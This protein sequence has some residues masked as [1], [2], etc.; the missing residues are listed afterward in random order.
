MTRKTIAVALSLL[1][2]LG[3]FAL[4]AGCGS[5]SEVAEEPAA[6][7]QQSSE[8][9]PADPARTVIMNGRS[10]MS[11]WMDHWG[12]AW[13]GPVEQ[14][15]YFLDYTELVDGDIAPSFANNVEGLAPGSVVFFKFCFVDFDG[16]NLDQREAEVEEVIETAKQKGLKL[17]IGNALPMHEQDS[18]SSLLEEYGEFN[19]F[20]EEKA[21]ENPG[22]VWVFDFYG[23]L[24]GSDGWLKAEYDVGDSHINEQAYS[25]LDP[26][27]F[28]LLDQVFGQ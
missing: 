4:A 7:D 15:G 25:D 20:L 22:S 21:A 24:A 5:S 2:A 10:V 11:G 1:V 13:E 12:Y 8:A 17:I 16:S 26:E 6:P 19:L 23:T 28:A 18:D 9:V 3:L 14:N 27:F